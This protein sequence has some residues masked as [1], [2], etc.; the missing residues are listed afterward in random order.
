MET[1]GIYSRLIHAYNS[2]VLIDPLSL[3]DALLQ[4]FRGVLFIVSRS[5]SVK[6]APQSDHTL[7]LTICLLFCRTKC[8]GPCLWL[9]KATLL[10]YR[11]KTPETDAPLPALNSSI[12]EH[13][14]G[15]WEKSVDVCRRS[16]WE[17]RLC[18]TGT[19]HYRESFLWSTVFLPSNQPRSRGERRSGKNITWNSYVE[20]T[21]KTLENTCSMGGQRNFHLWIWHIKEVLISHEKKFL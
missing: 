5:D 16:C 17:C 3:S 14:L 12:S 18:P 21:L 1:E 6:C 20:H 8:L 2:L 19:R 4:Y 13:L 9:W 10:K 15:Y 11:K 7:W